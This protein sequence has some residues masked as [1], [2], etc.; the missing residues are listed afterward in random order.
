MIWELAGRSKV[1]GYWLVIALKAPKVGKLT[2]VE[3]T[4]LRWL[5]TQGGKCALSENDDLSAYYRLVK[6]GYVEVQLPDR[7]NPAVVK[8]KLTESGQGAFQAAEAHQLFRVTRPRPTRT[9][10]PPDSA[11]SK[12]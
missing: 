11:S 3:I 9:S 4:F 12:D 10:G 5:Y 7:F 2:K 6:A 8:F 1:V